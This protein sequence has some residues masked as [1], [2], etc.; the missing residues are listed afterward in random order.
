M[1]KIIIVTTLYNAEQYISKCVLSMKQQSHSDFTCYITDD[2]STDN[3]IE[4]LTKTIGTD[5]RF[6]LYKNKVKAY[7]PGNYDYVIRDNKNIDDYDI[8]VE[9][10][11]DDWFPDSSVL[12]RIIKVYEDKNI[13][14]ANGSFVYSDGRPGFAQAQSNFNN[15]R[16]SVFSASHIRT[17]RAGLWRKIKQQDLKDSSNTYWKVAGDLA[18]MYPML[19]MAG[20]KRYKFMTDVNYVYNEETPLND[21]KVNMPLVDHICKTI[22]SMP[23]YKLIDVI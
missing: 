2:I 5:S 18:F 10:D 19:E 22:R 9:L 1:S 13:W 20:E 4:E 6:I 7:Q 21:H 12:D 15:L 23:S 17:W 16:S 11:G 14:I 8:I 3:S